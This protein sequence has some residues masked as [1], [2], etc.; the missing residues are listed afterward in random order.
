[1]LPATDSREDTGSLETVGEVVGV[2]G[3]DAPHSVAEVDGRRQRDCRANG[4]TR[5]RELGEVEFLD[6]PDDRCS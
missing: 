6:D 5:Q 2:E 3:D 4:L 1:M